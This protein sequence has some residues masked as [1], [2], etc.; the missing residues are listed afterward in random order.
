MRIS[1][2]TVCRNTAATIEDTIRSVSSQTH[3]DVEHIII[4][5]ASSDGTQNIIRKHEAVIARWVSEPDEGI[6]DGMNNGIALASGN[7]IGFLNADDVYARPDILET[8]AATFER[9]K[10]EACYGDI[11]FVRDD[12]ETVV[13]YYRSS[14]FSPKRLAYGWMPA[15]PGLYLKKNLFD[16][17]GVF[18]TDYRIAADYELIVRLFGANAIRYRYIPEVLVKM[19]LGG[20]STK[21]LRSNLVLNQEIVRACRENGISTNLFKVFLKFPMK[22]MELLVR[23]P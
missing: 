21:G 6:Y 23:S 3:C 17:Y 11:V 15:H 1:V 10:V 19:R 16:R 12:M 4:D 14:S 22:L 18:R 8:I 20:V 9:E 13:R 5:G 2:V 7:I